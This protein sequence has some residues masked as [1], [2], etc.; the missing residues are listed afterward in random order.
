MVI[1]IPTGIKI[2]SWLATLWGS[3]VELKAPILFALG[4][5]FLFSAS[6]VRDYRLILV[7]RHVSEYCSTRYMEASYDNQNRDTIMT[8]G[9]RNTRRNW[10]VEPVN[11]RKAIY[12]SL[13]P[14][15]ATYSNKARANYTPYLRGIRY[16]SSN[17]SVRMYY[18]P[19]TDAN[20]SQVKIIKRDSRLVPVV[21]RPIPSALVLY[22]STPET[23]L[24]LLGDTGESCEISEIS[25]KSSEKIMSAY[26]NTRREYKRGPSGLINFKDLVSPE[27]LRNA[28]V[29]LRSN[30]GMLTRGASAETLNKIEASWFEQASEKLIQGN[31]EYPN[32]RRIRIPKPTNKESSRPITVS[33]PRVK[34]IER[35]ILNGI[36]P[37]FEGSW[38]WMKITKEEYEASKAN[39]TVPSNDIKVS[40]KSHFKKHWKHI[41]KFHSSSYGFRPNRSA[42]GALKAIKDWKKNTAWIIDCD[43]RKAFDNVNR[44]RLKN[45]FLSHINEPLLWKEI[46]K[47]MNAGVFDPSLCFES[48]GV[49]QGSILS[50]FLFNIYMNELD[51]FV[52]QLSKK[53]PT[54][55]YNF[56]QEASKEYN[57]LISEFS[58]KRIAYT[59]AKYGSIRAMESA[60]KEKKKAYYIK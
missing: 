52:K 16:D 23:S 35:A 46:A 22:C 29:Q 38:S 4:F 60:L 58:T 57:R 28:W 6:L 1:A 8:V 13:K 10:S 39:S 40:K 25:L 41:T 49:P 2:F 14:A 31:F 17:I 51:N 19:G 53:L 11:T 24:N 18:N 37:L 12:I 44:K 47:M 48:M 54:Q 56:N 27:N 43:V 9:A 50:P 7:K 36:E 3:S 33:D 20:A 15:I 34:I 21:I 32:R 26:A 42:H 5:I 55:V 59:V 30:P 45:I